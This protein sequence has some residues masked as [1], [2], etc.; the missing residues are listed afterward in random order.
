MTSRRRTRKSPRRHLR[1]YQWAIRKS[2]DYIMLLAEQ[3][4]HASDRTDDDA[5]LPLTRLYLYLIADLMLPQRF[6]DQ[7]VHALTRAD[8]ER[9]ARELLN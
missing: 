1:I 5:I 3:K 6:V 8:A 7:E 4:A 2:I 9:M